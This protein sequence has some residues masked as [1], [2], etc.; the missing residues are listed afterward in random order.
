[1]TPPDLL[2]LTH[3]F[4][5]ATLSILH[6]EYPNGLALRLRTGAD[7]RGPRELHPAFFGCYD[8]H[9]AVHGHWQLAR[10]LRLFPGH[11]LAQALT[12]ALDTSLNQAAIAGEMAYFAAF[13]G[14]ETP[15]GTAWVLELARELRLSD[16]PEAA[17][18]RNAL[19][20][21]EAH[22][23][24]ALQAYAL[25]L[26][27]PVRSGMHNQTAF[28]LGLGLDWCGAVG[29]SRLRGVIDERARH[30]YLAD[31]DVPLA[32]EPS[33]ADFLSPALAEADLMRRVLPT[34]EFAGW[35]APFLGADAENALSGQL[36]P[37]RVADYADGQLAHFCGLNLSRAWMLRGIG[38]VLDEFN[39]LRRIALSI[40]AAHL[41]AGWRDALN[42]DYMVSHWAPS[43]LLYAMTNG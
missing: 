19:A 8:W 25:R 29:D 37:A 28:A 35:L 13:P 16:T 30:F 17:R 40:A 43:Y 39:P 2:T 11:E 36:Q 18:W 34:E 4:L 10:V 20:P 24:R 26:P 14:F 23:A 41:E 32:Y 42:D 31:R 22:A 15:Y 27:L 5:P 33:A 9:S 12:E 1:M 38:L 21:L 7:V 3:Q 6:R